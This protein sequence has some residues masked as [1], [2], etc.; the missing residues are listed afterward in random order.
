[1]TRFAYSH[2]CDD[3]R[4]ELGNK[5]SLI[6]LYGDDLFVPSFPAVLPKLCIVAFCVAPVDNL[7]NALGMKIL[8]NDEIIYDKSFSESDLSEA[9]AEL[10]RN[11][12]DDPPQSMTIGL[13]TAL[14][15]FVL[16]MECNIRVFILADGAELLAGRLRVRHI[17][18]DVLHA[19]NS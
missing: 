12:A 19:P 17:N 8:V 7:V 3:I 5:S 18:Q 1:M 10:L 14:S 4:L 2:F 11:T 16:K 6:G 15:P 13:N 9:Y